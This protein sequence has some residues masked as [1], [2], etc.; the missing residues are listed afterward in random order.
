[1]GR[2]NQPRRKVKREFPEKGAGRLRVGAKVGAKRLPLLRESKGKSGVSSKKVVQWGT[3]H[4]KK[5]K[6]T[7]ATTEKTGARD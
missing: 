1:M 2:R 3:N 6:V 5:R 7:F 4:D